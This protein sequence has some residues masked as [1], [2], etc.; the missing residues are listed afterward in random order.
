MFIQ[1]LSIIDGKQSG[2]K[3]YSLIF[4]HFRSTGQGY[5]DI[6]S[7]RIGYTKAVIQKSDGTTLYL[8]R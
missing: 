7:E 3:F 2:L 5:V 8:T 6:D 1:K 4:L